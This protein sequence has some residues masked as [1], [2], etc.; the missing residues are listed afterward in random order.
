MWIRK[1]Q[2]YCA[3]CRD[4]VHLEQVR[5]LDPDATSSSPP[6]KRPLEDAA[7]SP[8]GPL[9]R[10]NPALD[11]SL[12]W[13]VAQLRGGGGGPPLAKRPP[14]TTA[15]TLARL[16]RASQAPKRGFLN[17]G[18]TC[19]MNC[20]LQTV[21]HN[22]ILR[23]FFLSGGHD[24]HECARKRSRHRV[25]SNTTTAGTAGS[26]AAA[27]NRGTG[28]R[29]ASVCL[30]CDVDAL[31]SEVRFERIIACDPIRHSCR[32]VWFQVFC[33]PAARTGAPVVPQRLLHNMWQH[34]HHVAGYQQPDAHE[35]FMALV[36]GIH[37]DTHRRGAYYDDTLSPPMPLSKRLVCMQH[38][39]N[40]VLGWRV[41][42]RGRQGQEPV[43]LRRAPDV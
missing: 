35:F 6:R 42:A 33:S 9:R 11:S 38:T 12:P 5:L 20:I 7:D 1:S 3:S 39:H 10:R 27:A 43:R 23:S 18:S 25:T 30:G 15:A 31:V 26:E 8:R 19:F 22:P 41:A 21:V 37:S 14:T 34:A 28:G 32:C 29:R 24:P 2:V 40:S 13:F 16:F 36:G 4:V 17:M